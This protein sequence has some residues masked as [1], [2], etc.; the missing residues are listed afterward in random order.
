MLRFA[1]PSYDTLPAV[2]SCCRT[3]GKPFG[4]CNHL[5]HRNQRARAERDHAIRSPE[6]S[7]RRT[8]A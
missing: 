2:A 8:H 7:E 3:S 6:I 4:P 1:G 5:L